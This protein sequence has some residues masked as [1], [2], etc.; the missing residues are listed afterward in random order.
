MLIYFGVFVKRF[1]RKN[2][3]PFTEGEGLSL[4]MLRS[5]GRSRGTGPRAT[6]IETRA[7]AAA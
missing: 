6:V 4:A 2:A 3:V 1:F 7:G 5:T